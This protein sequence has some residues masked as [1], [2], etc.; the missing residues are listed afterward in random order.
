MNN[1]EYDQ[2]KDKKGTTLSI[3]DFKVYYQYPTPLPDPFTLYFFTLK[4]AFIEIL[5]IFPP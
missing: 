1:L 5:I 3:A 4:L 2:M